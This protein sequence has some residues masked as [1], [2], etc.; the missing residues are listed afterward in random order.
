MVLCPPLTGI[1]GTGFSVVV[2]FVGAQ[3]VPPAP[4]ADGGVSTH[5]ARCGT[6]SSSGC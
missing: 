1:I 4:G 5:A 3:E 2:K 6:L